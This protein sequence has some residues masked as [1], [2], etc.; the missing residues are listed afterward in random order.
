MGRADRSSVAADAEQPRVQAVAVEPL[1]L[2]GRSRPFSRGEP[3]ARPQRPAARLV[4]DPL[5]P[6]QAA[7]DS[8]SAWTSVTLG[9]GCGA[10]RGTGRRHVRVGAGST[11]IKCIACDGLGKVAAPISTWPWS[12]YPSPA[13]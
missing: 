8:M 11:L 6:E 9:T 1:R 3:P 4:P 13:D 5:D 7:D 2:E 12:P 10:C